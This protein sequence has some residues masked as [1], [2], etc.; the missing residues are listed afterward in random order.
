MN[1]D[2]K[3]VLLKN[4]IKLAHNRKE[5]SK[6]FN[7]GGKIFYR[8]GC[9]IELFGEDVNL[10]VK[11]I[12]IIL[13]ES[14]WSERFSEKYI[15]NQLN[16]VILKV[17]KDK[18]SKNAESYFEELINELTDYSDKLTVYIPLFG[19]KLVENAVQLGN[20]SLV[21][22]T[23]VELSNLIANFEK[24]VMLTTNTEKEK[25]LILDNGTKRI[26]DHI[27]GIVCAKFSVNAEAIRAKERGEDEARRIIDLFRYA[28]PVIY[29]DQLRVSVGLYG[30]VLP[31]VTKLSPIISNK[32][33]IFSMRYESTGPLQAFALSNEN[34][35]IMKEI[36]VFRLANVLRK[37]RN[38]LTDFERTL[39]NGVHWF[40]TSQTQNE[41]ENKILNL[42]ICLETFLVPRDGN[43]IGTF[44]AE[45]VAFILSKDLENR[46]LIKSKVKTFYNKRSKLSHG[47]SK[48]ILESEYYELLLFVHQFVRIMIQRKDEF[49]SKN[50]L[51]IWIEN[52]KL[53]GG[54]NS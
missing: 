18:H 52:E 16:K 53:G 49:K 47:G 23:D 46:L 22:M 21:K 1:P 24:V 28:I 14:N 9:V 26:K 33:K 43:P 32:G 4:I 48:D 13:K 54:Y 51:F 11:T 36:G 40:A 6:D 8:D 35:E 20:V 38:K 2:T 19:I 25:K 5:E 15:E 27:E 12:K 39:I 29:S 44:I 34:K 41:I 30:E 3:H 45:G 7:E 31:T 37:H 10:H 42:I 50:D 17:S